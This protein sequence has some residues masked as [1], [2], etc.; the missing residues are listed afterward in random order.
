MLQRR[1]TYG[2][3]K[4]V[5]PLIFQFLATPSHAY[6]GPGITIGAAV[7]LIIILVFIIFSLSNIFYL[8]FKKKKKK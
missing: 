6:I 1:R 2:T 4:I 5:I 7:V 8:Y 3:I